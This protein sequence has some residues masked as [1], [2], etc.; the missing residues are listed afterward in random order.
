M[1]QTLGPK[2]RLHVLPSTGRPV[3][4]ENHPA[5]AAAKRLKAE[6]VESA[7]RRDVA[8]LRVRRWG[9]RWRWRALKL[10][11]RQQLAWAAAR[12]GGRT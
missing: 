12:M 2:G 10:W 4:L 11:A 8:A 9:I 5:V 6:R 7:E 1:S 3:D